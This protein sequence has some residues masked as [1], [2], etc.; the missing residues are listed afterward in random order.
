MDSSSDLKNHFLLAMPL[1]DDPWF[2][3]SV[4]YIC[5]HNENGTMGLVINKPMGIHLKDIY[6]ELAIDS[7]GQGERPILQGGPVSPEQGFVLYEGGYNEVQNLEIAQGIRLSTSKDI[8]E[9]I[10]EGTGPDNVIVCLGYAGWSAGQL[11]DEI[12]RNS[13]LTIP[14]DEA[15]LF[16][17]PLE[18]IAEKAAEK[19]GVDLSKLSGQSGHA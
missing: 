9:N 13:W 15:L 10:A 2:G 12:A 8:L 6:S 3:H 16:H 14:A 11:E 19:L 1:L 17:T 7:D 5:D 4:C 18:D